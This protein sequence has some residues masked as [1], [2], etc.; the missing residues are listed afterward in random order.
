MTVWERIQVLSREEPNIL[1]N[2]WGPDLD[3]ASIVT[4]ILEIGGRDVAV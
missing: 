2:N 3:G 4:G 1:W